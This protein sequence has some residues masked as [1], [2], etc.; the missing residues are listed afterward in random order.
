MVLLILMMLLLL[1]LGRCM[2]NAICG[3]YLFVTIDANN[4]HR[5]APG[6][7]SLGLEPELELPL[8]CEAELCRSEAVVGLLWYGGGCG[9]ARVPW[10]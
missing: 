1:L 9:R 5:Q 3:G 8:E 7:D 6:W 4:A 10:W 2:P